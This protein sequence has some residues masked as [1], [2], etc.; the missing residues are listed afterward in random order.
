MRVL[1]QKPRSRWIPFVRCLQLA[2]G[3]EEGVIQPPKLSGARNTI[4]ENV[5]VVSGDVS[6]TMR[7]QRQ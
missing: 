1:V 3:D 5:E 7:A 4:F 6:Y 2:K